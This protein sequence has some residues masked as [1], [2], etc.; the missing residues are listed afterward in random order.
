MKKKNLKLLN[1]NKKTI[2]IVKLTK[3]KGGTN[4]LTIR[5]QGNLA[6]TDDCNG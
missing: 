6:E 5:T 2:S 1:L 4:G 3:I